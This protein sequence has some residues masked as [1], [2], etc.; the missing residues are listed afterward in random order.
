MSVNLEIRK[1]LPSDAI[2]FE[3]SAYDNSI[4]RITFDG[5]AIYEY[6]RMAYELVKDDCVSVDEAMDWIDNNTIRALNYISGKKPIIVYDEAW[7]DFEH[8]EH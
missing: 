2:V 1:K 7:F 8:E 3:N 4:I 6:N 5:R